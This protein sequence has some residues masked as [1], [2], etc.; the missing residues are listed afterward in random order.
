[1]EGVMEAVLEYVILVVFD[2]YYKALGRIVPKRKYSDAVCMISAMVISFIIVL[3]IIALLVWGIVLLIHKN[4]LGLL[5]VAAALIVF[6]LQSFI[7]IRF[8]KAR[9]KK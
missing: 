2:V 9:A 5:P 4:I 8:R 6:G 1:M 7:S 3:G